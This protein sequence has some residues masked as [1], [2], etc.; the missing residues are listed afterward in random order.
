MTPPPTHARKKVEII[1]E[2]AQ[3]RRVLDLVERLGA[4]GYT[5]IPTL[6]GKGHHGP[7]A[8][9]GVARVFESVMVIAITTEPVA[10]ALLAEV[11]AAMRD[12][13]GIVAVSDVEVAR[14][15]HF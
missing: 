7:R 13:I 9:D 4:T 2:R 3:M 14:P 8:E 15:E 10:K 1:V 5:V 11:S 12:Y 6:A